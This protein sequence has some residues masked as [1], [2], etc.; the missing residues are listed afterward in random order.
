M[1]APTDTL[2]VHTVTLDRIRMNLMQRL[3]RQ[4][5]DGSLRVETDIEIMTDMIVLRVS[6]DLLGERVGER[7]CRWPA[8]WWQAFK[9]RWAPAWV[10]RRWPVQYATFTVTTTAVYPDFL[11]ALPNERIGLVLAARS[12]FDVETVP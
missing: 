12:G 10:R 4:F 1:S 7:S 9:A 8:D 5:L 6:G 3:S 11:P 2:D